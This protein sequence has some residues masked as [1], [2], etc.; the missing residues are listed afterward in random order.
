MKVLVTGA[1]GNVGRYVA[2]ELLQMGEQV[3]AAGTDIE[4]LHDLFEDEA[5]QVILDFT[6]SMTYKK[7]L[8]DVDR[9]FLM[10]PPHLGKP[11]ELFPFIDAMKQNH[12]RFVSFL[13]LMGVEKN[14]LPPHHKIEKYI[15]SAGI[16]YGHIRPGFFMQNISGVHAAEIKERNQ[17]FIPAGRSKTSFIDAEDIGL[18]VATIL[19]E[20]DKYQNTAYTI[21]GPE[22]LDYYQI[23]DILTKVTGRRIIYT[24][25]GFLRYRNYYVKKRGLHKAYV[26]VTVALYFMTRL[27][28]AKEVT[29]DF[30]KLTGKQ[31][32]SFEAFARKHINC[33]I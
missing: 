26:N 33:F 1:S 12:I 21:T 30:I 20:P 24:K 7:A 10:R 27:G 11:K 17:I 18:A 19:H 6:D 25:P 29:I 9:V 3:V 16:P 8:H 23:A 22:A 2:H 4:K 5:E 15:E 31:P 28:T 13:S 32:R 14:S